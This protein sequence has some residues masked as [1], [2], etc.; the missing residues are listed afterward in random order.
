MILCLETCIL[1]SDN[2]KIHNAMLSSLRKLKSGYI[3]GTRVSFGSY[4]KFYSTTCVTN[5]SFL[6]DVESG[7]PGAL[8]S[9]V[10]R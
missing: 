9:D 7:R 8:V 2:G 5:L 6:G 1:S 4:E 3:E 10:E